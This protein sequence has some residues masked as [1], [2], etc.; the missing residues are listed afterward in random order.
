MDEQQ[1]RRV[2]PLTLFYSYAHEDELLRN[3]LEKHLS[4]LRRQGLISE[5]YDRQILAGDEWAH[6]IDEHLETASIILLLISADFLASN[7]CY[8]IEMQRALER[9]QAN[10]AYVIPVLVRPVDWQN[11][12]FAHL[13]ALPTNAKA[14]ATWKN[15]DAA[16]ADVAAG[17]RR[18]IE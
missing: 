17:L 2:S 15:R 10:Q 8:D 12:P 4:L 1:K 18:A 7:Y 5:W 9:H 3:Q 14:I 6:D 11:A 16:F 13:Q